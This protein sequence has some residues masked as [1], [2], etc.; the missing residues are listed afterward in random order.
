MVFD[1][2]YNICR[3]RLQII[4]PKKSKLYQQHKIQAKNIERK[5]FFELAFLFVCVILIANKQVVGTIM[6]QARR[7]K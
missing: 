4:F 2:K 1:Q 6:V 3:I 7:I 5:I